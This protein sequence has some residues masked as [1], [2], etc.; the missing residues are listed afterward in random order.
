MNSKFE[1][2]YVNL[3]SIKIDL[4]KLTEAEE[5]FLSAI[6]IN[7]NY[8]YAYRNLFRLYEKTNK[9]KKLKNKIEILDQN[10]NIAN[11][12]LMFKARISF[13]EKDFI[14]AKKFI[15]Q[16]SFEWIENTDHATN[17]LFWSFKAF[18]EE[19]VKNYDEAQMF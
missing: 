9:I 18:I 6:E 5:L 8:N 4:D 3:G 14:T 19:K 1:L 17:L 10:E 16:V 13:R 7:K 12:I 15:D 11:E 2:A